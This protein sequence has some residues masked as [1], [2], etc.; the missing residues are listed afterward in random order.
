MLKVS[1]AVIVHL[2]AS[3]VLAECVGACGMQML[4]TAACGWKCTCVEGQNIDRALSGCLVL[5]SNC[6]DC[7]L[8]L[9]SVCVQRMI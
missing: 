9:E 4:F 8:C 7:A 2:H 5:Q 6:F 3:G 1:T